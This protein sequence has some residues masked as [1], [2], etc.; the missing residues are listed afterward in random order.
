MGLNSVIQ[1]RQQTIKVKLTCVDSPFTDQ[2]M[3][4]GDNAKFLFSVKEMDAVNF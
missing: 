4:G 3:R 2:H 1:C